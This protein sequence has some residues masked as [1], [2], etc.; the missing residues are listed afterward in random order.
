M[1]STRVPDP[2]LVVQPE[3]T[4]AI[5]EKSGQATQQPR[6]VLT[7]NGKQGLLLSGNGSKAVYH[8]DCRNRKRPQVR[9][10]CLD[11]GKSGSKS[12]AT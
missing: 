9:K 12:S 6:L 1:A 2:F 5:L 7:E 11:L 8:C 3:M 4:H 10:C